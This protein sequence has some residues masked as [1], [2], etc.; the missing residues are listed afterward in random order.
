MR[1]TTHPL[2]ATTNRLPDSLCQHS[3]RCPSADSPDREAAKVVAAH[4]EQGWN[5]LCNAVLLFDD[6]GELLPDG[7]V[8]TPHRPTDTAGGVRLRITATGAFT[9]G[10]LGCGKTNSA[11][12]HAAMEARS[13][14]APIMRGTRIQLTS[15]IEAL[16]TRHK[17]G[18]QGTVEGVHTGGNLTVRMDD[19]RP[20]FPSQ[21]EVTTTEQ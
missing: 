5:V 12:L 7:Q 17:A 9:A 19:G 18:D 13:T 16:G 15:D 3:P 21:D 4:Q 1:D 20:N 11:A 14:G 10:T 2:P 8:V 6:T